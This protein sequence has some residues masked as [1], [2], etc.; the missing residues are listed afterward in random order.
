VIREEKSETMATEG[1]LPLRS[2]IDQLATLHVETVNSIKLVGA[3]IK[4]VEEKLTGADGEG[5]EAPFANRGK[6]KGLEFMNKCPKFERGRDRW[7]DFS[8]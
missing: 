3:A 4:G 7:V 2:V 1:E 8:T 6:K 5:D